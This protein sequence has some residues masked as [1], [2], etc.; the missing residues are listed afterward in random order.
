[1]TSRVRVYEAQDLAKNMRE[2]FTDRPSTKKR[3]FD[4][5][6]P[7]VWQNV[8]DSLSISYSSDKWQDDRSMILY[9]HL[10]ESRN[11][12]FCV[13]E[14]LRDYD[15]PKKTWPT[16]GPYVSFADVPMPD[17]FA[18]LALF[19]DVN[20]QLHVNGTDDHPKF[21]KGDDGVVTVT[22]AHGMLGGGV[23]GWDDGEEP[24]LFVYTAKQGPL[25]LV[26]GEELDVLADGIV[27]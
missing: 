3:R 16:I 20:F 6:W 15:Q 1:M 10:A 9:R 14:F 27:G 18:M 12:A 8:G 5:D 4:F 21:G 7:E 25:I 24:F 17:S 11:Q 19:E 26:I 22:V 23:F 13:P 2:V